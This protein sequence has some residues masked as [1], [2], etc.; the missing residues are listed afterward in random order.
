MERGIEVSD[1]FD[2]GQSLSTCPDNFQSGKVMPR[3]KLREECKVNPYSFQSRSTYNGAK[4]S[5]SFK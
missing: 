5:N 3:D 1:T 2:I 4:S